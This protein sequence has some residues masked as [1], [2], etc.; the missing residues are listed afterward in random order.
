[1]Y[2]ECEINQP[3]FFFSQGSTLVIFTRKRSRYFSLGNKHSGRLSNRQQLS[4]RQNH[5]DFTYNVKS[6]Q[7]FS[8]QIL[9]RGC[10]SMIFVIL[11]G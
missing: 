7:S 4:K 11:N 3:F 1:M 2:Y 8:K 5:G 9:D 6:S 10:V